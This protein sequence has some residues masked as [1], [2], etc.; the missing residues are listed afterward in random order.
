MAAAFHNVSSNHL[1]DL[2]HAVDCDVLVCGQ[3]HSVKQRVARLVEAIPGARFVDAG[4]LS[5]ARI[6]EALTA[7]LI[8]INIR[9]KVPGSGIRITGLPSIPSPS[10]G[11]G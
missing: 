8:G 2:D 5:S 4:P 3:D 9:Y 7:L 6:V 11:E 10:T 1:D